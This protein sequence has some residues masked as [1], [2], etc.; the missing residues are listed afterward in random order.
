MWYSL[1]TFFFLLL[2]YWSCISAEGYVWFYHLM[3]SLQKAVITSRGAYFSCLLPV[4]RCQDWALCA[5]RFEAG[6]CIYCSIC[7]PFFFSLIIIIIKEITG[8]SVLWEFVLIPF[9]GPST[10]WLVWRSQQWLN[11]VRYL[12]SGKVICI[13]RKLPAEILSCCFVQAK[14]V[15]FAFFGPITHTELPSFILI[16]ILPLLL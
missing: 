14:D 4:S 1:E 5:P 10:L 13:Q 11:T 12:T 6:R 9:L 3:P 8:C 15:I 16:S 7:K 2:L